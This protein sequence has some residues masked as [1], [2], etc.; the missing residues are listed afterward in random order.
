MISKTFAVSFT[1]LFFCFSTS[2]LAQDYAITK[3]Q[4]ILTFGGT[5]AGNSFVGKFEEWDVNIT[6]DANNLAGS[7]LKASFNT[8]TA[9]T[10][11]AMYDGT[12]PQADW[13]DSKN[14]P[15][16]TFIS[17]EITKTG[18]NQYKAKGDLAIRS[19][20][21]PIEFDFTT[22]DLSQNTVKVTGNFKIDRLAYDIGLKSDPKSEWVSQMID[23]S[24]T[25]TAT[26]K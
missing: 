7:S 24:M 2:S 4:S 25:L 20:T 23:V 12:L 21:K 22:S 13:F 15:S 11:N 5:H 10:G 9:K 17:R 19:I 8:A 14:N 18:D 3:D 16:A 26:R 1:L 6:F